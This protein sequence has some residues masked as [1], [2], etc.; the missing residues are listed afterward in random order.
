MTSRRDAAWPLSR[1]GGEGGGGERWTA[2]V[3]TNGRSG[4]TVRFT[5]AATP[6]GMPYS[7]VTLQLSFL[8]PF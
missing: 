6:R 1:D 4:A 8:I 7:D 5:D 3:Q 2:I